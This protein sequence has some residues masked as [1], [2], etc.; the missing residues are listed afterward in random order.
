MSR[1]LWRRM[2]TVSGSLQHASA[3]QS[4]EIYTAD[5]HEHHEHSRAA[6]WK[7]FLGFTRHVND[8]NDMNAWEVC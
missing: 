3:I 2:R 6:R 1:L 5:L 8:V 4:T 7:A